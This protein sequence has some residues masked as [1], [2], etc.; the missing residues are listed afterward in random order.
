MKC[1]FCHRKLPF[2]KYKRGK[3]CIW[4]DDVYQTKQIERNLKKTTDK[5]K[6]KQ[7]V[8]IINNFHANAS[9]SIAIKKIKEIILK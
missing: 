7:I 9:E 5:N 4:C 1:E 3:K 2:K 8:K 6:F